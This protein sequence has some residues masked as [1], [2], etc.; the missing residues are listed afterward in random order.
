MTEESKG[1]NFLIRFLAL[2]WAGKWIIVFCGVLT[3]IV[4]LVIC[5]TMTP[6]YS[7]EMTILLP[8]KMQAMT[9]LLSAFGGMSMGG[10]VPTTVDLEAELMSSRSVLQEVVVEYGLLPDYSKVPLNADKTPYLSDFKANETGSGNN[11]TFEFTSDDGDYIV[12]N[13][14]GRYIGSGNNFDRFEAEGLSFVMTCH[15]PEEGDSFRVTINTP[16]AAAY[17]LS[18]MIKVLPSTG[19]TIIVSAESYTPVMAQNVVTAIINKYIER[20]ETYY[21]GTS[22]QLRSFLENQMN[23]VRAKL[24]SDARRLASYSVEHMVFDPEI[25]I[26]T[27]ISQLSVIEQQRLMTKV[28]RQVVERL[29]RSAEAGGTG[30]SAEAA[31]AMAIGLPG[32]ASTYD[33]AT[34]QL[35]IQVD[36]LRVRLAE[37]LTYYTEEH[38]QVQEV[39]RTLDVAEENLQEKK[40]RNLNRQLEGLRTTELSLQ[41]EIDEI[42]DILRE[43]P[44]KF[45]EYTQLKMEISGYSEMYKFL[46]AQYEQARLEEQR[47]LSN[48]DVPRIVSAASYDSRPVRPRKVIYTLI[49]GFIGGLIGIGLVL[50]RDYLRRTQFFNRLK[51]ETAEREPKRKRRGRRGRGEER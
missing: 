4:T 19:D 23:E 18:K 41:R 33:V 27:I 48:R 30:I 39:Q 10:L 7:S 12:Y 17:E 14:K 49:S 9:S 40:V 24:E 43:Q 34:S 25:E 38:P 3:G 42:T 44:P 13:R 5:F 11:Y 47:T 32:S 36:T 46:V 35:E 20:T 51:A 16:E 37:L 2:M 22:G 15:S 8:Q 6:I 31:S 45:V 29:L 28:Q 50:S 21:S 1:D 26:S